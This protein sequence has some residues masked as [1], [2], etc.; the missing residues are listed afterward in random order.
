MLSNLKSMAASAGISSAEDAFNMAS[1]AGAGAL[2][3]ANS[4]FRG[5]YQVGDISI[6]IGPQL[7]EGGYSFVHLAEEVG[8]GRQFAL[9][10][11]V[12]NGME[13]NRNA[14][15]E[16]Q[17]LKALQGHR[18]IMRLYSHANLRVK[19]DGMTELLLLCEL[20]EEGHLYDYYQAKGGHI[21]EEELFGLFAQCCEGV[22]HMHARDPPL[23]HRDVKV[24][25]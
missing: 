14:K 22:G 2:K 9:K 12:M 4:A 16:L 18:N 13:A 11:V 17:V 19:R 7:A 15:H 8:T 23:A 24:L 6:Q 1:R 10:R 25:G 21:E 3:M 20:C 5:T